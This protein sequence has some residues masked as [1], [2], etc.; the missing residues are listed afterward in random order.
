MGRRLAV[1]ILL[2]GATG[3]TSPAELRAIEVCDTL[4]ACLAPLPGPND[5]CNQGCF[6]D[7]FG[8]SVSDPC[9]SCAREARCTEIDVCFDL[10]FAQAEPQEN[11]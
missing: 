1:A 4:C 11:R 2:I 6:D 3:C 5:E 7:L 10:C 9:L 8:Q